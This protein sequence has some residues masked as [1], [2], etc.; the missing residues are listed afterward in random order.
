MQMEDLAKGPPTTP[1]KKDSKGKMKDEDE[2]TPEKVASLNPTR[3][4]PIL[5]RSMESSRKKIVQDFKKCDL[6]AKKAM[7]TFKEHP[8][9]L[10]AAD[11]ALLSFARTL[12]F[13]FETGCRCQ[14][15]AKDIQQM[16]PDASMCAVGPSVSASVG[17]DS[18]AAAPPS[19]SSTAA[20]SQVVT[21]EQLAARQAMSFRDFLA[22]VRTQKH[23]FWD[24]NV[25]DLPTLEE[26]EEMQDKALTE[27]DPLEFAKLKKE[28]ALKEKI[29]QC[30]PKAIKQAADDI[31]KH[32]KVKVTENNREKRRRDEQTSKDALRKI[33]EDAQAA[34]DQVKRRKTEGKKAQALFTITL[35]VETVPQ[36]PM[37]TDTCK[38]GD[39]WKSPW[40]MSGGE[41]L[42]A[43][44]GDSALQRA[45]SSWGSQYKRAMSNA[46]LTQ[47]SLPMDDKQGR[48]SFNAYIEKLLPRSEVPDISEVAGGKGF[49]DATWLFGLAMDNT[50][51]GFIPNHAST[52]R[53]LV[54]GEVRFFIIEWCSLSSVMLQNEPEP[55]PNPEALL[56]KLQTLDETALTEILKQGINSRQCVLKAKQVLFIPAGWLVVEAAVPQG[57]HIYGLRKNVFLKSSANKY[58]EGIK[59]TQASG[60]S[61]SACERM[62]K[63]LEILK[64]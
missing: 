4:G 49:M 17:S 53:V 24:G 59:I 62:R 15:Q 33:R 56:T 31:S 45:L 9:E 14:G 50:C 37:L 36:V 21:A 10:K 46:K 22:E 43:C 63:V 8:T 29:L 18:A 2:L 38:S 39:H 35:P 60:N 44:L 20:K 23:K 41:D 25:A 19:P 52:F 3:E 55:K 32:M 16:V 13:R 57:E 26:V 11:R 54:V 64:K 6:V 48:P 1:H 28:W 7:D 27:R 30:I 58:E 51:A 42:A 5:H 47:A 34:A 12:Q 40:M 61:E